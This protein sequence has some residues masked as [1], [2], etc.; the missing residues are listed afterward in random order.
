MAQG[1]GVAFQR[2]AI[3]RCRHLP[4]AL[5]NGLRGIA[6][7]LHMAL[8]VVGQ[9]AQVSVKTRLLLGACGTSSGSCTSVCNRW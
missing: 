7:D 4:D 8:L 2:G 6:A 5:V 3:G 9:G 1:I